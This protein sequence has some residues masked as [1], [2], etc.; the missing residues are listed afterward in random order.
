MLY[1]DDVAR[2]SESIG[3]AQAGNDKMESLAESKLL[4]YNLEKSCFIL[5]GKKNAREKLEEQ[6]ERSPLTLCGRNM[7]QEN[8]A[9]Y[10]G[11]WIA[12]EG[13]AESVSVT[14]RKRKGTVAMSIGDIRT[15]VD[16]C[17]SISCRV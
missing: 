17:R 13:L 10:L 11:D 3:D 12:S 8:C 16:D 15:I 4:D 6:N 5:V 9:K 1:Q 14:V 2:I 7:V